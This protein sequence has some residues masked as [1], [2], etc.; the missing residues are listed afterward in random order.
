MIRKRLKYRKIRTKQ[1]CFFCQQKT[2]VN[3][4]ETEIL[5]RFT[6]DRGKISPRGKSGACQKH[7][8]RVTKAIK[9]ARHLALLPFVSR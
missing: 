2:E 6:S 9:R 7:Q 5:A 4:L 1:P 3:F 8:R